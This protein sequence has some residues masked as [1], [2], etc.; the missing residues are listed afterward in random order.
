MSSLQSFTR[1][2]TPFI[3][4]R[5][6]V[7]MLGNIFDTFN[8]I[9]CDVSFFSLRILSFSKRSIRRL[10]LWLQI[11]HQ[12]LK[13]TRHTLVFS[14]ILFFLSRSGQ[15]FNE[16]VVFVIGKKFNISFFTFS[17]CTYYS[18]EDPWLMYESWI[19]FKSLLK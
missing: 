12:G 11:N 4:G 2:E 19:V 6:L 14:F 15:I 17:F 7:Y 8:R 18:I 9:L 5:L 10:P 3:H 1:S 13:H 16:S